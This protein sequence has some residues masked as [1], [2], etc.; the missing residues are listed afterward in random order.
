MM[1]KRENYLSLLGLENYQEKK[2]ETNLMCQDI[3]AFCQSANVGCEAGHHSHLKGIKLMISVNAC[4]T[5]EEKKVL[6]KEIL[7]RRTA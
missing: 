7:H 6:F 1:N 3:L 2:I 4:M 5:S